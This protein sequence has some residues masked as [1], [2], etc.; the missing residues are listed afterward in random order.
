MKF[1]KWSK[2]KARMLQWL[3]V[4]IVLYAIA[5]AVTQPQIQTAL[6]KCG[7]V[8]MAAWLGYMIDRHAF[9][10]ERCMEN[11]HMCQ[12]RRAII[13]AATMLAIGLGL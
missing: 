13:M 4:A 11:N 7:N 8:T 9:Y 10:Y 2:D 3:I 12:M 6:W 1:I 5:M